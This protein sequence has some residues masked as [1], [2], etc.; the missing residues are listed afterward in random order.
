ME[1]V[2]RRARQ[3][4][5]YGISSRF[6][7][8]LLHAPASLV[9]A[10]EVTWAS[11]HSDGA[12]T[13]HHRGLS[14]H[15]ANDA[16]HR[17]APRSDSVH[18]EHDSRMMRRGDHA[19]EDVVHQA[20]ELEEVR[21][22]SRTGRSSQSHQDVMAADLAQV[23]ASTSDAQG[24]DSLGD[25]PKLEFAAARTGVVKPHAAKRLPR[26][27]KLALGKCHAKDDDGQVVDP[28]AET[29]ADTEA[30]CQKECTKYG[31]CSHFTY[32]LLQRDCWLYEACPEVVPPRGGEEMWSHSLAPCID[33]WRWVEG[34][35]SQ[36]G[37]AGGDVLMKDSHS[38]MS[39]KK[40]CDDCSTCEGFATKRPD[41]FPG[42]DDSTMCI[43]KKNM[44]TRR[45]LMGEP[46]FKEQT[47]SHYVSSRAALEWAFVSVLT[48]GEPAHCDSEVP[49]LN[50]KDDEGRA[51][52]SFTTMEMCVDTCAKCPTCEGFAFYGLERTSGVVCAFKSSIK[53]SSMEAVTPEFNEN[54][55]A[56]FANNRASGFMHVPLP[57]MSLQKMPSSIRLQ[58]M[59]Q[60]VQVKQTEYAT[61]QRALAQGMAECDSNPSCAG[62][63]MEAETEFDDAGSGIYD[64]AMY[65]A[66]DSVDF[67]TWDDVPGGFYGRLD[68]LGGT[69]DG[70]GPRGPMGEA[71]GA[72]PEGPKGPPGPPGPRGEEGYPG[73]PGR[74]GAAGFIGDQ[75][76]TPEAGVTLPAVIGLVVFNLV[77][78]VAVYGI[79][80]GMGPKKSAAEA[81][82]A[83]GGF[84]GEEQDKFEEEFEEEGAEGEEGEEFE[85][86]LLVE[87]DEGEEEQ[88]G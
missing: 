85:E 62:L 55:P 19:R 10:V 41:L 63:T 3:G 54:S 61:R 68:R 33:Y 84:G 18:L 6:L 36:A 73:E 31:K 88:Q 46:V 51:E 39:C 70:Q 71:G 1:S 58:K 29:K 48:K 38:F 79:A 32:D 59:P 77:C 22:S 80:T 35:G 56:Y 30:E 17:K 23:S 42:L 82:P 67:S 75:Q 40:A 20:G 69:V 52:D 83:A 16:M 12:S 25:Q 8:V 28:L 65:E 5:V 74:K 76:E 7:L 2:G 37:C 14:Q 47:E 50:G 11:V 44:V 60:S 15:D 24:A 87:E 57:W 53:V 9:S 78:A 4:H 66:G 49:E 21:E 64:I 81:G 26:C 34:S 72:G 86:G 43:L 27:C 45:V 13:L